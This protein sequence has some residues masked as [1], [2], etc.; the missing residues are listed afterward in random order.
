[1]CWSFHFR[2]LQCSIGCAS[3]ECF[4]AIFICHIHKCCIQSAIPF[5]F[6]GD[7]KRIL[8]FIE[9]KVSY[10][11][12]FRHINNVFL[13]S[14]TIIKWLNYAKFICLCFWHDSDT[15][16]VSYKMNDKPISRKTQ[17]KHLWVIFMLDLNWS[18]HYRSI[19]AKTYTTIGLLCRVF[20]VRSVEVKKQLYISPVLSQLLYCS[21]FW[22][23]QLI[24][25]I[26]TLEHI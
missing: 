4:R 19:T 14:P 7:T 10:S 21:Q 20:K 23:T 1:M 11:T 8:G 9:E 2:I 16:P 13:Q 24:K 18:E 5:I 17:H 6:A 3:K 22:R 15:D 25:D 12:P 26:L